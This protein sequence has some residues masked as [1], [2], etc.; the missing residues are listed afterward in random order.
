MLILG[1]C[2]GC[3]SLTLW[4]SRVAINRS[5]VVERESGNPKHCLGNGQGVQ[6]VEV[7]IRNFE[8]PG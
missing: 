7:R 3:V 8:L 1:G 4:G 6:S 5:R 2:R